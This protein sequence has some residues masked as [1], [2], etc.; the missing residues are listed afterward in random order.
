MWKKV[1]LVNER[2]FIFHEVLEEC[3]RAVPGARLPYT[4]RNKL[5]KLPL[6]VRRDI[7]NRVKLGCSPLFIACKKGRAE[8]VEYLI[9][10]CAADIELSG[11]YE[12]QDDRFVKHDNY[13]HYQMILITL[14]H[15]QVYTCSNTSLVCSCFWQTT[16]SRNFI[17]TWS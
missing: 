15:S 10:V 9:T 4:T 16:C 14:Y 8:I 5:E 11:I 3:K 7:V 12:V 17:K 2:D 6:E 1:D 13:D